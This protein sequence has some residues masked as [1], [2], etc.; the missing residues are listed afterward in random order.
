MVG[1]AGN[2]D[3]CVVLRG[4]QEGLQVI[5]RPIVG[6]PVHQFVEPVEQQDDA[7]FAQ[8]VSERP[9]IDEVP[10]VVGQVGGDQP[11][12]GVRLV[13]G[14][15][16]DEDRRQSGQ[17]VGYP[18][19]H[20]AEGEG[21]APAEVAEQEDEPAVV[22]VDQSQELLGESVVDGMV[23][24]DKLAVA[25]RYIQA[26]RVLRVVGQ[27]GG[28]VRNEVT[29]IQQSLELDEAAHPHPAAACLL[30]QRRVRGDIS[31]DFRTEIGLHRVD[32]PDGRL[33]RF[34]ADRAEMGT[35]PHLPGVSVLEIG[36]QQMRSGAGDPADAGALIAGSAHLRDPLEVGRERIVLAARPN[37]R[38][39]FVAG[40]QGGAGPRGVGAAHR[41]REGHADRMPTPPGLLRA[42][43]LA[44]RGAGQAG[45]AAPA[46][47][48]A[49]VERQ[50]LEPPGRGNRYRG[51]RGFRRD[52]PGLAMWPQP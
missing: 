12:D 52:G 30:P 37:P 48:P 26:R 34:P 24:P 11:V 50:Q 3:L 36:D 6:D 49:R 47:Q 33:H 5:G 46:G 25:L 45:M 38:V 40:H 41:G 8:H 39:R 42:S 32:I 19:G 14:T 15:E 43:G 27:P 22:L 29:E 23:R 20:L 21:L 1:P 17:L 13:Q 10:L 35:D 18:A 9:E 7:A 4:L 51:Q 2:N 16:L 28:L 31:D 44:S